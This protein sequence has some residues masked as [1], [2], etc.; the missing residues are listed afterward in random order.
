MS[1][2]SE[3]QALNLTRTLS[4]VYRMFPVVTKHQSLWKKYL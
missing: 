2:N 1:D 3:K 4:I